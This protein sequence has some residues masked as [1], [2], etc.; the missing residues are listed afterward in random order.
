MAPPGCRVEVFEKERPRFGHKSI[1]GL[2]VGSSMYHYRNNHCHIPSTGGCCDTDT[3]GWLDNNH[4]PT[5][6]NT[7]KFIMILG[8]L[9]HPLEQTHPDVRFL[10]ERSSINA[11]I[12]LIQKNYSES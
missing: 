3:I 9:V 1:S 7:D 12:D 2:Y 11:T 8:D 6:T 4:L 5:T 10:Q